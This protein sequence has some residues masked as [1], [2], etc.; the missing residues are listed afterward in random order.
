MRASI[1]QQLQS[2]RSEQDV[3][4]YFEQRYG[5]QIVWSPPWHGFSLLAWLVPMAF[6]LCGIGLVIL[7]LREWRSNAENAIVHREWRSNPEEDIVGTGLVPVREAGAHADQMVH[8]EP[9]T[10]FRTGT[11]GIVP[12]ADPVPT[13]TADLERY[14]AQL[15][16]ELAE[17]DV[18]FRKPVGQSKL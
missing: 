11:V 5:N 8:D 1:R 7:L 15:E 18:L 3:I 14:R 16:A 6:L 9:S 2:G 10:R 4:Q 17:D 13:I 12:C